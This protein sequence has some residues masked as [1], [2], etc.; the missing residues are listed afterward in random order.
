MKG[1]L[2][3]VFPAYFFWDVLDDSSAFYNHVLEREHRFPVALSKIFRYSYTLSGKIQNNDV[4]KCGRLW[5]RKYEH[6][7]GFPADAG[8]FCPDWDWHH[9]I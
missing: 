5:G 6:S 9:R 2:S 8:D 3:A 4:K 1:F 7:S